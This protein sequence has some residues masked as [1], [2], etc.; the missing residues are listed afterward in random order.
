MLPPVRSSRT[1]TMGYGTKF[2]FTKLTTQSSKVAPGSYNPP[3]DFDPEKNKKKGFS[4]SP[5]REVFKIS[6]GGSE[7]ELLDMIQVKQTG[8]CLPIFQPAAELT[9]ESGTWRVLGI[10]TFQKQI[11]WS[12]NQIENRFQ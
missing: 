10:Q 8:D 7:S 11:L 4:M 3:S 6:N 2:D 9:K 1:T 12:D 5:G